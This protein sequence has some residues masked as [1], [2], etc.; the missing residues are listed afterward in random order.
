MHERI[1]TR[2]QIEYCEMSIYGMG[3][4]IKIYETQT[5]DTSQKSTEC[6][7]ITVI[8]SMD[9]TDMCDNTLRCVLYLTHQQYH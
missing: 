8:G 1:E 5:V 3:I 2:V 9:W 4:N 7:N 6:R